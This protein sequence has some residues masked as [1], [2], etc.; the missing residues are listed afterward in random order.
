[1]PRRGRSAWLRR[2]P[3]PHTGRP[4][5][6]VWV[7]AEASVAEFRGVPPGRWFAAARAGSGPPIVSE[8]IMVGASGVARL[9]LRLTAGIV[10]HGVVR[11]AKGRPIERSG[12]ARATAARGPRRETD[13]RASR[14][15]V[16]G[17]VPYRCGRPLVVARR[18]RSGA[19]LRDPSGFRRGRVVDAD[20]ADRRRSRRPGSR[21]GARGDDR[22]AS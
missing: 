17:V 3:D 20:V 2:Q 13:S 12:G 19:D 18:A 21:H 6:V 11:D 15:A 8:P 16:V 14:Q 22:T 9:E 5:R 1:V 4:E 7:D 10:L